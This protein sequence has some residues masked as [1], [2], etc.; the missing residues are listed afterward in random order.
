MIHDSFICPWLPARWVC[1]PLLLGC[2][3]A[4][5]AGSAG[6]LGLCINWVSLSCRAGAS[7]PVWRPPL[8]LLLASVPSVVVVVRF[9][10]PRRRWRRWLLSPPLRVRPPSVFVILAA[11][12]RMERPAS[13][14][15]LGLQA[16][17]I[18][19][20]R[21]FLRYGEISPQHHSGGCSR[22][23]HI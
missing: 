18:E 13:R 17:Y 5:D 21:I 20:F 16:A 11:R 1:N 7:W 6:A 19:Y 4:W 10:P 15:D 14:L 8:R 22:V 12:G 3:P 9:R 23:G 2:C